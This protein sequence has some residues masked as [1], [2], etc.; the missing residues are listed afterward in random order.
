MINFDQR[1]N[2]PRRADRR[3]PRP[4][5]PRKADERVH[6]STPTQKNSFLQ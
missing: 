2:L 4:K 3:D 1:P 6:N 5:I